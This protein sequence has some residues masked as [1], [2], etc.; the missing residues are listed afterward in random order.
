MVRYEI[1]DR[2][3]DLVAHSRNDWNRRI[4]DGTRDGFVVERPQIFASAAAASDYQHIDLAKPAD[5][6]YRRDYLGGCV[7]ALNGG[8]THDQTHVRRAA[9][10]HGYHITERS[11]IRTRH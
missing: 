1:G 7:G 5:A 2:D 10:N 3:V 8:G 4:G 11:A 9:P 6:L